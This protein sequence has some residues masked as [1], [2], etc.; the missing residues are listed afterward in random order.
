MTTAKTLVKKVRLNTQS[1]F[2]LFNIFNYLRNIDFAFYCFFF[3]LILRNT[4]S[5]ISKKKNARSH[6]V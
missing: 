6:L 5:E 4:A 1:I 2:V 3:L